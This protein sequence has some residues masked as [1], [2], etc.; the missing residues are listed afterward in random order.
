MARGPSP[1]PSGEFRRLAA[2]LGSAIDPLSQAQAAAEDL[3]RRL[4]AV[5]VLKSAATVVTDGHRT[6]THDSPNSALATAGS[7][8][9]LA[10]LIAGLVAQHHRRPLGAGSATITS[11]RQGGLSL[12]DCACL[13]VRAH[14]GAAAAWVRKSHASGGLLAPDLLAEIPGVL[15]SMRS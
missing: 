6:W 3:A 5:V 7:G 10:G 15:E 8:D 4:G 9:V 14:A 1:S 13:G 12:Y 11:E 2:T